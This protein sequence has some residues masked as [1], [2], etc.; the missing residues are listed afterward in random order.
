MSDTEHTP[1]SFGPWD[2]WKAKAD[3]S[4]GDPYRQ[5][6]DIEYVCG[7]LKTAEGRCDIDV[8]TAHQDI[9]LAPLLGM[10]RN[11]LEKTVV[12]RDKLKEINAELLEALKNLQTQIQ[13]VSDG[14][15]PY[16]GFDTELIDAVIDKAQ[17]K[18]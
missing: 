6:Q 11:T 18:P 16:T 14:D 2:G 4:K 17:G 12:E 15:R 10:A 9:A 8:F 1:K 3:E 5:A 7:A 13:Q